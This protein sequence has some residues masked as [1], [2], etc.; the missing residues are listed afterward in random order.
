MLLPTRRPQVNFS[1]LLVREP[2]VVERIMA[3]AWLY[4]S[5]LSPAKPTTITARIPKSQCFVF[6]FIRRT[7]P[8]IHLFEMDLHPSA[9]VNFQ[10]LAKRLC[11]AL[12]R[13]VWNSALMA[14]IS[15]SR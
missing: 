7:P 2:P 6:F 4:A 10:V 11:R 8:S 13:F 1:G 12:F 9:P 5:K 15:C 14:A 3:C